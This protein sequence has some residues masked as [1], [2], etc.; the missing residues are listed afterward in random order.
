MS[1]AAVTDTPVNGETTQNGDA[2]QNDLKVAH[3]VELKVARPMRHEEHQYLDL[4]N[5]I[6]VNGNTRG[7]RTGTGTKS[8]F[9]AQM[10][11]SL[12]N[13]VFPLLT[14]KKVF[15]RGI[16]EELLWFIRGCTDARELQKKNVRI[17]D[18]NSSREFLDKS[19]FT[20]REEGDLGPV[21]GFQWR[22]WGAEYVDMNTDYTGKGVDQLSNVIHTI[23]TNPTCRRII[24]SAW[25][26]SDI[27]KMALP[28]CHLLVQFYVSDGELSAQ[29]YQRSADMGLG[30]PFNIAS[31]ALLTRMI[32]KVTGLKA[33]DFIHTLGDAHV[34][35]NHIEPLQ[36]QLQ[37]E[38]RTFPTLTIDRD[39]KDIHDFTMEDFKV[40]DYNPH[41]A[42]KMSMAV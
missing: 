38:P 31:Y 37:R 19:G 1:S 27:S 30:V 6:L 2:A 15:L 39:V 42:I 28:P 13:D 10:R 14:T 25:N 12:R 7:D 18:G 5:N 41:P 40:N 23:K 33:G 21:Y 9:G 32:A 3:G 11:Y 36:E 34:Y 17:W 4:I 20:S 24:M 26:V 16:T 35:M 22:H 29:L 8:I